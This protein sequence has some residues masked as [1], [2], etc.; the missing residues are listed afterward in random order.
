[1]RFRSTAPLSPPPATK[2]VNADGQVEVKASSAEL[3]V[4]AVDSGHASVVR[5]PTQYAIESIPADRRNNIYGLADALT[6][7]QQDFWGQNKS[8]LFDPATERYEKV[9]NLTLARWYPTLVTL[10]DGRVLAVSGLDQFGRMIPGNNEI[11]DPRTRTW[12]AAPHLQRTFPTYPALFPMPN[13]ELFYSGSNAGY[14]SATVGRTPGIWNL[15]N[16]TFRVVPGP[17][18]SDARRRRAGACCCHRPRS[19]GT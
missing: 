9:G 1:M 16:N 4:E 10:E 2:V 12:H 13:G 5:T 17:A 3:W 11:F 15:T 18:R 7:R 6:M 19:S 14:G 8:Y